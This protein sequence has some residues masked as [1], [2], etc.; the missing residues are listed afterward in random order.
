M[1]V[2]SIFNFVTTKL[3]KQSASSIGIATVIRPMLPNLQPAAC[4]PVTES[5]ITAKTSLEMT[6]WAKSKGANFILFVPLVSKPLTDIIAST[7]SEI[8]ETLNVIGVLYK[9][10]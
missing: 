10:R 4:V 5:F 9:V 6:K 1:F 8:C 3:F 7:L 2:K